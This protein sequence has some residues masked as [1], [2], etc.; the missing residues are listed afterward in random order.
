[1][2]K[3]DLLRHVAADMDQLGVDCIFFGGT[4]VGVHLDQLPPLEE[5]RPTTDVHALFVSAPSTPSDD[6]A[7][8]QRR[9]AKEHNQRPPNSRFSSS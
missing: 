5:E 1:M 8:S 9:A 3:L 4:V 6:S 2:K 7:T